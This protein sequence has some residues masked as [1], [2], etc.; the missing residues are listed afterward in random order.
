MGDFLRQM[1]MYDRWV[2]GQCSGYRRDPEPDEH[3]GQ[4]KER[5]RGHAPIV[6]VCKETF[7]HSAKKEQFAL[8]EYREMSD[9]TRRTL[10]RLCF[11]RRSR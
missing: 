3:L 2:G 4:L 8:Q 9:V 10:L 7:T 6:R 1:L 5:F 11:V